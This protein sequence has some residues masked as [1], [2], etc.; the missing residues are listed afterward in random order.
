MYAAEPWCWPHTRMLGPKSV[1]SAS[2]AAL[3]GGLHHYV[4][5]CV[6]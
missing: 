1:M 2:Y 5:L 6:Y 4:H 3:L